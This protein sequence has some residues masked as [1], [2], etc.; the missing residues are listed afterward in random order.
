VKYAKGKYA[1]K[2]SNVIVVFDGFDATN[3]TKTDE[4]AHR[5]NGIVVSPDVK[6]SNLDMRVTSGKKEFLRNTRKKIQLINILCE[7]LRRNNIKALQSEGDADFLIVKTAVDLAKVGKSVIVIVEDTDVVV[8]LKHHWKP[9][10]SDIYIETKTK[11]KNT[12]TVWSSL[13]AA[14]QVD[15]P[16]ILKNVTWGPALMGM[17]H[18]T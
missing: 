6:I 7:S 13:R 8:M 3:S 14:T 9:S 15:T 11:T 4:H 12:N 16:C 5:N 1:D 10:M 2:A 18:V 17:N